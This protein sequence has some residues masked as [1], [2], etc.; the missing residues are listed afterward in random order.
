MDRERVA[1]HPTQLFILLENLS[2]ESRGKIYLD[3]T[4]L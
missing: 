3:I 1:G 2:R 4:N